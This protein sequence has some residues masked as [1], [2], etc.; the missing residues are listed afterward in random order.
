MD[1]EQIERELLN[2][3]S[4]NGL[5][6]AECRTIARSIGSKLQA[7]VWDLARVDG[8]RRCTSLPIV[9]GGRWW[10]L[11]PLVPSQKATRSTSR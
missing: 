9:A 11:R 5:P 3:P 10:R 1:T 7:A 6:A 2:H 4:R 8:Y